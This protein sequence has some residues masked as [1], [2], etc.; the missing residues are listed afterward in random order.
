MPLLESNYVPLGNRLA[1]GDHLFGDSLYRSG[2]IEALPDGGR[3]VD[4]GADLWPIIVD[5]R[6]HV[7]VIDKKGKPKGREIPS[8]PP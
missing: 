3:L 5:R 1:Q 8:S 7:Q 6:V 2:L 4:E